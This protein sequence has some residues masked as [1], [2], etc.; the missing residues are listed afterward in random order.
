MDVWKEVGSRIGVERVVG[1]RS[2]F[3]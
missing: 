1:R 2:K 3:T